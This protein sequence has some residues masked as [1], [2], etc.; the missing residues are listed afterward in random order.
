MSSNSDNKK[1]VIVG[2]FTLIGIVF[3]VTAIFV[4]GGNQKRFTK[5]IHLKAVFD[6]A[7]GLK[8]GNNVVFSGVKIGTIKNIKLIENSHVEIDFNIEEKS[9]DYIRKD[10]EVRI[11]SEGFIGNKI[12]V[13][14]GGSA[15]V[16]VV[17]PGDL[18]QSVKSTDTEEMMAT[19]QVNNENLVAIT[20]DVKK[21]SERI[22]NG[23]GTIG[24]VLTDSLMA[25]QVKSIMASLSQ[26]AANTA[27]VSASLQLFTE[28]LNTEGSLANEILTDTT[29]YQSLRSSAAQLA[30]ITQTT[31]SLTE[32]LKN[33]TDKMNT[34]DNALGTLLNDEEMA[35][36][37]KKTMNNLEQSTDKLNQNMEALQHNFLFRGFFRKQAKQRAKDEAEKLKQDQAQ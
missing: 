26:T 18:L 31:S 21:L 27:K 33:A 36:Q 17:E 19:L 1:S 15:D 5:T 16:A 25:L 22:T 30:G 3:F 11:S 13:I 23:E 4:L 35:V 7:G 12:I 28:K 6:N 34:N 20:G 2:L 8:T 24:A 14:Q 37:M 9:Q 10:A 32:N 29:V